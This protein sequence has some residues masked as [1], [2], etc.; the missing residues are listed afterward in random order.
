VKG[1]TKAGKER[2]L[3]QKITDLKSWG[4]HF[5]ICFDTFFVRIH[6]LMYGSYRINERKENPRLSLKF[7]NGEFNFYNCSVKIVDGN[8]SSEYDE[9]VDVMS[10]KW[11]EKK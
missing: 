7:K 10:G 11:N 2:L 4:K 1:N 9:E 6:F 8:F 3:N 5:I